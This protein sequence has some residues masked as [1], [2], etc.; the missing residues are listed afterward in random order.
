MIYL[1]NEL[2]KACFQ[3]DMIYEDF[4]GV[5]RRTTF[6]EILRDKAFSIAKISKG[7][8]INDL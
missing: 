7:Y 1:S 8:S 5:T 6:D 3:H 4:K 2:S